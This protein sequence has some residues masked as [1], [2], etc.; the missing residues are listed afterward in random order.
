MTGILARA[1]RLSRGVSLR[2]RLAAAF[3]VVLVFAGVATALGVRGVASVQEYQREVSGRAVPYLMGLSD[4]ALAAKAAA[5]DERGY[6]L[7]GGDPKFRTEVSQRRD[8][9]RAGLVKARAAAI[10]AAQV[11]A[12]DQISAHLDV[13]NKALDRELDLYGTDPAA[14]LK[15]ALGAN[16]DLR[17]TYEKDFSTAVDV[18][19]ASTTVSA[20]AA[21]RQSTNL[22]NQLLVLFGAVAL[23][24]VAAAW[25]LSRAIRRP[26]SA[27]VAALE[28]AAAGDLTIRAHL[29]GAPEIRRMAAAANQMLIATASA[30]GEI[31][32]NAR[33]L[34]DAA[35][36]LTASSDATT[37]AMTSAAEQ[38][39]SVSAAAQQV[40]GNV[41]TVSAAAVELSSTIGQ[42]S[43]SAAGAVHVAADAVTAADAAQET[44]GKLDVSSSEIGTVVKTITAIAEQTNLLALNATIEAARAGDAGKGFAVV[45]GEVKD[46]AQETA[47]AT[48]DI[49]DRVQTIQADTRRAIDAISVIADVIKQINEHQTAIAATVEEQS[50]TTGEMTRSANDAAAG[51]DEIAERIGTVA[52]AVRT[53]LASTEH[54]QET[55]RQLATL[56]A[57]LHSLV[58]RFRY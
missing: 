19:K 25:L 14:A 58:G 29:D 23:M 37:E 2:A 50:A 6:L 35:A 11:R 7:S 5:N 48:G 9:E 38:A 17:K 47:R 24:G 22:R 27:T 10:N 45:A 57:E 32:T 28:T 55:A 12:V 31:S 46:L 39:E 3:G 15:L 52:G 56:G 13:F 21:E 40:S 49:A 51:T 30:L 41:Q 43:G 8:V 53:T 16:R 44:V 33:T 26:L 36:R 1:A 54:G 42:I 34:N 20:A 18:A 4:A